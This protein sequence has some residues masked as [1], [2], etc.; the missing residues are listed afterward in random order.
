MDPR[1]S[2]I[3]EAGLSVIRYYTQGALVCGRLNWVLGWAGLV[4]VRGC[5]CSPAREM[6]GGVAR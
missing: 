3:H 4:V 1:L 2:A 5:C 6:K